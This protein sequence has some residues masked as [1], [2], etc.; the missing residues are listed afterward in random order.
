M[1]ADGTDSDNTGTS[2]AAAAAGADRWDWLAGTY[3][4]VPVET[5][6]AILFINGET[7]Q[8]RSVQD[9]TVWT[10]TRYESGYL[11]GQGALSVDGGSFSYSTIVGSVTPD[12]AVLLS[13]SGAVTPDSAGTTPTFTTGLGR[14]AEKD[15]AW[16]FLMQM[17]SGSGA[18]SLT[19]WSW[20]VQTKP[21]DASWTDL[22]GMSGVGVEDVFPT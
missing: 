19:H 22:P 9:Q 21:G 5:L 2:T 12:G 8:T 4:Y 14:M 17:T 16:A 1:A 18:S 10:F 7:P 6:P 13:F 11:I 15:G 20:M 3:W